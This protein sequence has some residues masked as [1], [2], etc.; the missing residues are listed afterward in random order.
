MLLSH[1]HTIA[2]TKIFDEIQAGIDIILDLEMTTAMLLSSLLVLVWN[3]EVINDSFNRRLF[4]IK[5]VLML[6]DA[7]LTAEVDAT[8]AQVL[9]LA[10]RHATHRYSLHI[11]RVVRVQWVC[12]IRSLRLVAD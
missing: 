11:S 3:D 7:F 9:F 6:F 2:N 5:I 10:L 12:W 1:E 8:I 4:L